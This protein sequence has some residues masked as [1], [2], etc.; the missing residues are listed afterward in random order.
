MTQKPQRSRMQPTST[1]QYP[2]RASGNPLAGVL[3]AAGLLVLLIGFASAPIV[4][5]ATLVG[6]L[7]AVVGY[8]RLKSHLKIAARETQSI[9]LPGIGTLRYRIRSR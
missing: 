2:S 3:V 5:G 7:L 6:L 8:R 4:T 1:L 9:S